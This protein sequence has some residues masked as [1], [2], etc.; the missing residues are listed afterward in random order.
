MMSYHCYCSFCS[1]VRLT[2]YENVISKYCNFDILIKIKCMSTGTVNV[3]KSFNPCT[4]VIM[5]QKDNHQ[6]L[7]GDSTWHAA[8]NSIQ[9]KRNL[10]ETGLEIAGCRHA[11]AQHAVNMM[12]GEVYGYAHYMQ[13]NYFIPNNVKFF[14]Y[15]V[16]CKYWP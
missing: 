10:S 15:D 7:C 6:K 5:L 2:S 14:W 4:N 3:I 1:V 8:G 12:Y 16:V 11:L 9:R 13:L